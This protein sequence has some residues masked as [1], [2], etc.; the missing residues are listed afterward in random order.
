MLTRLIESRISDALAQGISVLL[1]G[2]RQTGKTTSLTKILGSSDHLSF[3]LMEIKERLR[4]ERDPALLA[5]EIAASGKRIVFI[6]EIQKIPSL[7][8]DVQ[9]LID[10]DKKV[11][12]LTGSS[13][14]KLKR[15]SVNLLPGRVL[16]FRM[17]PVLPIEYKSALELKS[18][19]ELKSVLRHGEL[20]R[21]LTLLAESK[22]RLAQD[23]L[24]SY[25]STY[26]EEEIRAEAIV[27]NI[28]S[29]T[30][31]LKLAAESS[32]RLVSFRALA[33]DVGVSH[34][35]ISE[36]FRV[37][38]DCLIVERIESLVP[39]GEAGKIRKAAKFLFFDT[40]V[41]NAAAE[42][43]GSADFPS[44]LWGNLFE[45]WVG[46]TLIRFMRA[47]GIDGRLRYWR[48]YQGREIDW[49]LE[50]GGEWIPI[51]AKWGESLRGRDLRHLDYFLRT[52]NK[53][54]RKG[55]IVST[56]PRDRKIR[57]DLGVLSFR[58]F[59]DRIFGA[60]ENLSAPI[61]KP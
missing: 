52:Y 35:T 4:F 60:R 29:F 43:L 32:G 27:R 3:N 2:P 55:Y 42:V 50:T 18:E 26:L 59:P 30:R 24:S 38:E 25:A 5:Q 7:L 51:E 8:D 19:R 40:G 31:F 44:E 45:Q 15:R 37:L 33:Q 36:H 58:D 56:G 17:D 46:L 47:H 14:R 22:E 10:R 23:L 57:D 41:R 34:A 9:V 13:A 6:D 54:A 1:L 11:F 21:V 28:G 61:I 53:K 48:D 16:Q 20:P 39:S 49:V 12:A